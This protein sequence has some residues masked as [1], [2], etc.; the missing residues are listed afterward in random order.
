MSAL[1]TISSKID[2]IKMCTILFTVSFASYIRYTCQRKKTTI[3]SFIALV[4][5]LNQF[6]FVFWWKSFYFVEKF[7]HK[8]S[9]LIC[10]IS[11]NRSPNVVWIWFI[12]IATAFFC[13][14]FFFISCVCIFKLFHFIK[15]NFFSNE[16]N[17]HQHTNANKICTYIVVNITA[18][19]ISKT[20][21]HIFILFSHSILTGIKF[22]QFINEIHV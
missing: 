6:T 18:M 9:T 10:L 14:H 1:C 19:Y 16:L 12:Q 5:L 20:K 7:I 2:W 15:M 4:F 22:P 17:T 13:S 21:Y 3:Y 8:T 11:C